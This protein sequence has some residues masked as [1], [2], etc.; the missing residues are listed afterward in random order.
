MKTLK[1]ALEELNRLKRP[2]REAV[3]LVL[4]ESSS[5]EDMLRTLSNQ[6]PPSVLSFGRESSR[7]SC[8]GLAHIII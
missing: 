7:F 2:I 5:E 6:R 8:L 3:R 4:E 1:D